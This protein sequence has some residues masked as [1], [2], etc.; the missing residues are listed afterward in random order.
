M[1]GLGQA[2][3]RQ[4]VHDRAHADL[5]FTAGDYDWAVFAA[6]QSA[7]KG[8]KAVLLAAGR[9]SPPVHPLKTLF[10]DLVRH[11]LASETDRPALA[12]AMDE[13]IQGWAV[14]RCPIAGV[15]IA[16]TD[17]ISRE[18]A[19]KMLAHAD[20]ILGFCRSRGIEDA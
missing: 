16:P 12:G 9:P 17:L 15:D 8:L 14:S 13:L 4:A 6:Q 20:A 18:Q 1:S 7:E 5:S 19:E 11:G 2:M 10:N 3:W